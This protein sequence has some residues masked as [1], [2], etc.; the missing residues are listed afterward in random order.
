MWKN[1]LEHAWNTRPTKHTQKLIDRMPKVMEAIIE[2]E[3]GK[4]NIR[5]RMKLEIPFNN[6]SFR[7]FYVNHLYYCDFGQKYTTEKVL[8]LNSKKKLKI[9][10]RWPE[11]AG[12]IRNGF[13]TPP[14]QF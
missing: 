10:R 7:K 5:F 6:G 3:G 12:T 1:A 8:F 4:R 2:A 9:G 13:R 14:P 11:P